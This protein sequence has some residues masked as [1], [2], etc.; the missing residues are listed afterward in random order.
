[1]P[2]RSTLPIANSLRIKNARFIVRDIH[3]YAE[4]APAGFVVDSQTIK[5]VIAAAEG[6]KPHTQTVTRVMDFLTDLGKEDVQVKKRRG[7]KFVVDPEAAKRYHNRCDRKNSDT[8]PE[9]V[10][11][12]V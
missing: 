5:K 7:K 9:G 4:K 1:M 8:P 11:G 12:T 3:D 2:S 10:I 6:K